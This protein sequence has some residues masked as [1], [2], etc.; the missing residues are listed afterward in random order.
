MI[1]LLEGPDCAGKTTLSKQLTKILGNTIEIKNTYIKHR[2]QEEADLELVKEAL[3][4]SKEGKHVI[5]DRLHVS[6][7][8][9]G[10]IF[11]GTGYSMGTGLELEFILNPIKIMCLPSKKTVLEKFA[12]RKNKEMFNT[13]DEVYD[14]YAGFYL[15]NEDSWT[16]YDY[17]TN[18]PE[19]LLRMIGGKYQ[20]DTQDF[21][22][23]I[24]LDCLETPGVHPM[25]GVRVEHLT[26]ELLELKEHH[27]TK[28]LEEIIDALVD[29]AYI[30]IGTANICGFNFDKHWNEV[31]RANMTKKRGVTKRG[32]SYD[33]K[34]PWNWKAPN[35]KAILKKGNNV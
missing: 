23:K 10:D 13:V 15:M 18:T 2:D 30:A 32:H 26:E 19:G 4:H 3:E 34:K 14:Q 24:N 22:D 6:E 28:N 16:K 35:H 33:A 20:S 11:R 1:I 29:I 31:Q 5:I 27:K 9:Y 12:V 8:I 17:T 7:W 21:L 25:L